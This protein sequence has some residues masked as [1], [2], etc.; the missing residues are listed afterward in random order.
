MANG[1][2]NGSGQTR[3]NRTEDQLHS[4]PHIP[5]DTFREIIRD[6]LARD[7]ENRHSG[8]V[9][10]ALSEGRRLKRDSRTRSKIPMIDVIMWLMIT[11]VVVVQSFSLI[12]W[13]IK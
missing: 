10:H 4:A 6:E 13:L 2:L 7:W 11:L 8:S 9:N 5:P 12:L 1:A 3:T